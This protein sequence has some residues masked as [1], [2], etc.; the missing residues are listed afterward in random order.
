M[1]LRKSIRLAPGLRLNLSKSGVS[2]S[3]GWPGFTVNTGPRGTHLTLGLPGTGLSYRTRLDA[4]TA[5]VAPAFDSD[6]MPDAETQPPRSGIS[7]RTLLLVTLLLLGVVAVSLL[8]LRVDASLTDRRS[9]AYPASP[10]VTLPTLTH[11]AARAAVA[12]TP[13]ARPA[14]QPTPSEPARPAAPQRGRVMTTAN[15]RSG[16]GADYA[17]VGQAAA[18]QSVEILG[19]DATCTW[20]RLGQDIGIFAAPG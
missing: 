19:C 11:R 14:A 2:L 16:P 18:D 17:I 6:S 7:G 10:R 20:F 4:G 12:P 15:L 3:L 8:L 9:T 1:A 5:Y 13:T